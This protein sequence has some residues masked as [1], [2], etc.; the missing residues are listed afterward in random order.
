MPT[1]GTTPDLAAEARRLE[2]VL[3]A[4]DVAVTFS[5]PGTGADGTEVLRHLRAGDVHAALVRAETMLEI[6]DDLRLVAVLA[7]EEPRDVVIP[8]A[9]DAY[10]LGTLPAG[11]RVGVAN[12]RRCGF[13]R[14]YRPDV[15]ALCP[16]NG[17]GPVGA[18]R[19][20]GVDAIILGN[21]EARRLALRK[22]ASEILDPKAWVPG[23]GQGTVLLVARADDAGADGVFAPADD[24]GAR[25]A[26]A[27]ESAV[28][29]AQGVGADAPIGV[30]ALPHGPWIRV[31]GMVASR[32]GSRV[33]RGD[34]TGKADDPE[35]AGRS[36]AELL[37]ARG[38]ASV[39]RGAAS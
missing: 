10:T 29:R 34:V 39:L 25:A 26:Y 15:H 6:P 38:V 23:P 19:S 14:S 37:L 17:E 24:A 7:R 22:R 30:M 21:A 2:G 3:R 4:H 20:G 1:L 36:L 16:W 35:T 28:L 9:D 11:A 18:L 31:W 33:V 12:G 13:L 5:D 27:A 8:C 32:D